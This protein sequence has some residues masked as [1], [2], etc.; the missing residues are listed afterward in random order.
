[1]M[2]EKYRYPGG[3]Y[4][5]C[6]GDE[7]IFFGRK[8]A[9]D[10][11]YNCVLL[12]QSVVIYGN[13]GI[14]KTSLLQAGVIHKILST[15]NDQK[16]NKKHFR[17]YNVRMGVW[18]GTT[19]PTLNERFRDLTLHKDT[20]DS[21]NEPFL[22]FLSEFF[23]DE[24][25]NTLWYKFKS[26]QYNAVKAKNV[27]TY[28]LI[29]DQ[30]EELFTYPTAQ[31][32]EMVNELGN[33]RS[34][35][36]PDDVRL[37][38]EELENTNNKFLSPEINAVLYNPIPIK[39]IF[40][41]RSDKLYLIGRLK[42]SIPTIM[43]NMFELYPLTKE[44]ALEAIIGPSKIKGSFRSNPFDILDVTDP[45]IN[46]LSKQ[47]NEELEYNTSDACIEPF[48]LQIICRYIERKVVIANKVEKVSAKMV[49]DKLDTIFQNFYIEILKDLSFSQAMELKVRKLI[50]EE[51]I[52]KNE[53]RR[54]PVY[55]K[56]IIED[57]GIDQTTF[58]KIIETKLIRETSPGS[59]S[60]EISHDSLVN[61]ILKAKEDRRN[62][63]ESLKKK[64]DALSRDITKDISIKILD[65][66][67]LKNPYDYKLFKDK[68]EHLYADQNIDEALNNYK[69]AIE[70][71]RRFD[72]DLHIGLSNCYFNKGKYNESNEELFKVIESNP[73]NE[74][75]LYNIGYNF[76]K[77]EY[78]DKAIEY[79]L[80]VLTLKPFHKEANYNL[81]VIYK[82][83]KQYANAETY[84]KKVLEIYPHEY[85]AYMSLIETLILLKDYIQANEYE[86]KVMD[87]N[88][89][90]ADIYAKIGNL[91]IYQSNE[92]SIYY[93]KQALKLKPNNASF[94]AN[95]GIIYSYVNQT[96]DSINHLRFACKYDPKNSFY[97]TWLGFLYQH[98]NLLERAVNE[99][100]KAVKYDQNYRYAMAALAAC[101]RR[102]G[103]EDQY[104]KYIK[105]AQKLSP[106]DSDDIYSL[107]SF[108]ALCGN[109]EKA[110]D[111]L[112]IA[113]EKKIRMPDVVD[114]D[115]DFDFIKHDPRF[116]T[117][118]TEA[119]KALEV[120]Q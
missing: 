54:M 6:E 15:A 43:Q 7:S 29:I 101:Y 77:L 16:T 39:F 68:A 62:E 19:V 72:E 93:Y 1:M 103:N 61:P 63:E 76:H 81:A 59:K 105:Q 47:S 60:Y 23:S 55:I 73:K 87:L 58:E 10:Y 21:G 98:E 45:V 67:I 13:S 20:V 25:K 92:R 97:H 26:L 17:I 91:Y 70:L 100:K 30:V 33:L 86:Q 44:Q 2:S 109:T 80:L 113:F 48:T 32:I 8:T 108:E 38:V 40:S 119:K 88:K 5:F 112:K 66:E 99:F 56:K 22:P 11:L 85:S 41:I 35:I 64:Y 28:I 75:A 96:E 12:N 106:S 90:D 115:V 110:L 24:I 114:R 69:K 71:C 36:L 78:Y 27:D 53:R 50:E 65:A 107:A 3:G 4:S 89:D 49:V 95:L 74:F 46:F 57:C 118:L 111:Y 79:Y 9:L 51:M 117:L 83:T 82:E 116:I 34:P 94:H 14:G 102:L 120:E 104:N 37:A 52:Y 18:K 42:K 84:F 31:L